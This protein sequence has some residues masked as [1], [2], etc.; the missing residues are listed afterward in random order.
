[1]GKWLGR[2]LVAAAAL[3][4]AL[5]AGA[6]QVS[7]GYTFLKAVKERDAEKV[8]SLASVPGSIVINTRER[9]NGDGALHYVA[10]ERDL[11]WL[12]F[13]LG[14][15][16]RPDLQNNRGET[17]LH[18]AAQLGWADGVNLLL[19]Q[20][21]SVDLP[22]QGGETALIL[23]VHKRDLPMVRLLLSRGANPRR[24]DSIAGLSALEY[25]KR[26][27]R[28]AMILKVLETPAAPAREPAGPVI[29]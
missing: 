25:A 13:L 14:K 24:A 19:G 12:S 5:P 10:R 9:G 22:N 6:Q 29:R 8:Q 26:D 27:P 16:A 11:T 20:R 18:I 23:A 28:A 4:I 17:A 7:D 21:A 3:A 1:M 15:G 2:S